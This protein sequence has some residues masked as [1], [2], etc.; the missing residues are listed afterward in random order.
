MWKAA[1]CSLKDV[2]KN[3][4]IKAF[5]FSCNNTLKSVIFTFFFSLE[6]LPLLISIS[7]NFELLQKILHTV[8]LHF[9]MLITTGVCLW[10]QPHTPTA[11]C[12]HKTC[13]LP[14]I[15]RN[16]LNLNH[17][18]N[19]FSKWAVKMYCIWAEITQHGTIFNL[20]TFISQNRHIPQIHVIYGNCCFCLQHTAGLQVVLSHSLCSL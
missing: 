13:S 16:V 18:G 9:C 4:R 7:Q 10:L 14:G 20:L 3:S 17:V 15:W 19:G 2:G 1:A 6:L 8:N 11:Q 5:S 12:F